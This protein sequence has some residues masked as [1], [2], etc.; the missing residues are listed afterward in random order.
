MV[1]NS[2]KFVPYKD[3]KAVAADFKTVYHSPSEESARAALDVF[4]KNWDAKYPMISR[5]WR[6]KWPEIVPFLKFSEVIRKAAYTTN[7]I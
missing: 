5:S 7:T 3:R 4:S 2:L 6:T 1:R